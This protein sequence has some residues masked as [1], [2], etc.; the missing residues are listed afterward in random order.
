MIVVEI[1]MF[2]FGV[3]V[4]LIVVGIGWLWLGKKLACWIFTGG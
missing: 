4:A 3:P 2:C 1:L